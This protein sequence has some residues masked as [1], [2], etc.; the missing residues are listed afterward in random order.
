[1]KA[2]F[3]TG[4]DTGVG[5]T[6]ICG[7]LASFLSKKG[8]KVIPQ[9]W[10]HT[11]V[12]ELPYDILIHLRM[13]GKSREEVEEFLPHMAPYSFPLPASPHLAAESAG[14]KI[15]PDTIEASFEYLSE[16]FDFI[17]VEGVGGLMVP[18]R[19]DWLLVD[20]LEKLN[21]PTIVVARNVLGAI[22]HTLLTIEA[23]RSHR[24]RVLGVIFNNLA[25]DQKEEILKDN[26]QVVGEISRVEVLGVMPRVNSEGE[27][28]KEFEPI[29]ERILAK[30]R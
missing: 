20:L 11:G 9:K 6:I 16:R 3:V 27:M 10:V 17:V 5:K 15:E 4:T 14:K 30:V 19:R 22:N 24:I 21:L 26:P 7:C 25:E 1:M 2:I 29:G 23:L 13:L 12:G 18:L 8:Y 28:L